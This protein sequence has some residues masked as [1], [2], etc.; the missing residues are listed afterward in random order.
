VQQ[1]VLVVV[2]V[3]MAETQIKMVVREL[4]IKV[5]EQDNLLQVIHIGVQVAVELVQLLFCLA[6]RRQVVLALQL[7]LADH[8]LI[9]QAVA[10]ELVTAFKGQ[11]AQVAV[12]PAVEV[13]A[14]T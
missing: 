3:L 2:P 1:A 9:T 7:L 8:Q 14:Q 4:R 6:H 11:V 13:L 10:V 12:A 5:T